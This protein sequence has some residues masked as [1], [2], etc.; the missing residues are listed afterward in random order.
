MRR[1]VITLAIGRFFSRMAAMTHPIFERYAESVGADF[2]VISE[3]KLTADRPHFEKF[4]L[5]DFL[6]RYDR[7]LFLDTDIIVNRNAPDIFQFV[8]P[9]KFGAYLVSEHSDRH[10]S[11]VVAIQQHLGALD[12]EREYFNSGVMLVGRQHREIFDLSH[13]MFEGFYEQTQLNYNVRKLS[14]DVFDIGFRFNHTTAPRVPEERFGSYI[15]YYTGP[16]HMPGLPKDRQVRKD[17]RTIMGGTLLVKLLPVWYLA[18]RF[19][20]A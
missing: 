6:D 13:G 18:R 3:H 4:Q 9:E 8:P 2:H 15:I 19:D 5:R 16:G 1:A 20:F 17:I 11:S 12:W 10:D 14:I 7:V